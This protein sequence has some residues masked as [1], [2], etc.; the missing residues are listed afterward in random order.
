[1]II[2]YMKNFNEVGRIISLEQPS[3]NRPCLTSNNAPFSSGPTYHTL[4]DEVHAWFLEV[5]GPNYNS[6]VYVTSILRDIVLQFMH[7]ETAMLFKLRWG[8]I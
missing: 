2:L 7:N 1:M 3:D 5:V 6:E 4:T 8:G